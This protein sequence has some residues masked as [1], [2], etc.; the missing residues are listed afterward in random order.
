MSVLLGSAAR[1][2]VATSDSSYTTIAVADGVDVTKGYDTADL[3]QLGDVTERSTPSTQQF[4]GS[5][6]GKYDPSDSGLAIVMTA[7]ATPA[8]LWLQVLP[9]GSAG[10]KCQCRIGPVKI[11]SKQGPD[12]ATFSFDFSAAGGIAP[13]A[14]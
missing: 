13:V 3:A 14:V 9:N 12:A 7:Q 8:L 4:S 1:V 10:W 6:T 5:V 11:S 2:K